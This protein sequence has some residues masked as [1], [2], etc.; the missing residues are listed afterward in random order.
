MNVEFAVL[1]NYN[2]APQDWWR[3]YGIQALLYDRSDDGVERTFDA[4]VI[5]TENRGNVDYDKLC[6]LVEHYHDLPEVFLWSKT[7]IFKYC[8]K[9]TLEKAL[10]K[11]VFRPLMKPDH[12]TYSNQFGE[13]CRYRDGWYEEVNNSWY[14]HPHPAYSVNSFAEWAHMFNLPCPAFLPFAPGGSY[15]LTRERVH[16]FSRDFYEKMRDTLPYASLPGEAQMC[17]RSY[18]LMWK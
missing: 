17:E 1:V 4:N 14:L 3:E 15:I 18:G 7:N 2:F 16:R 5:R 13:V 6:Y 11:G 10:V 9:D 12:P 8:D